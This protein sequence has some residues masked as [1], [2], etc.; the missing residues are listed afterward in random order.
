[1]K[2][3]ALLC[4]LILFSLS[5][6]ARAQAPG[7]PKPANIALDLEDERLIKDATQELVGIHIELEVIDDR[8]GQVVLHSQ[9]IIRPYCKCTDQE[10]QE[11]LSGNGLPSIINRMNEQKL[12]LKDSRLVQDDRL[13]I[14]NLKT[15]RSKKQRVFDDTL[16]LFET[17]MNQS[18]QRHGVNG[19]ANYKLD[20]INRR[21]EYLDDSQ[22]VPST[23]DSIKEYLMD[24]SKKLNEQLRAKTRELQQ[25][26]EELKKQRAAQESTKPKAKSRAK[27]P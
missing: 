24:Y 20:L 23:M 4:C 7:S 15:Y 6:L 9:S 27:K 3:R 13:T 1:M 10:F 14:E 19:I 21:F 2:A 12:S 17:R 18:A 26:L 16:N 25:Q 8:I 11:Y 5:T 22:K